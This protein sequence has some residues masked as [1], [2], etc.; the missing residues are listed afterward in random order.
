MSGSAALAGKTAF[1][2]GGAGAIAL[3]SAKLLARDGAIVVL[4]GRK[5]EAMEQARAE[6][7]AD[8]PDARVELHLG[9][10][11][12]EN[13]VKAALTFAHGIAGRLDIVVATVGGGGFKPFLEIEAAEVTDVL[14][15]NI[16]SAFL[17]MRHGAP[18][19][20]EGGSIVCIS[21]NAAK[22][23]FGGLAIYH[24][25][26]AGL[27]ALVEGAAEELGAQGIRVNAV[28]PGLTRSGATGPMFESDAVRALF[29]KEY[30]LG[31]LGEAEDIAQAVRYLAGP[32]A[33]WVTGQSFAVDGG[34]EL[35]KNPDLSA[36][37][38]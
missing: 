1:L 3:A 5:P 26:K 9:D 35:R 10:A 27:E 32:E 30:P 31:R 12:A 8:H 36:L 37:F 21:S 18:L 23:P 25:A 19:M 4:M 33:S 2:T 7:L 20:D 29:L 13:D 24:A 38:A 16:T 15:L 28:R 14:D 6:I 34:N 17:T 22:R 11:R